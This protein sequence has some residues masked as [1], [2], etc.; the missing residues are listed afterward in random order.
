MIFRTPKVGYVN[1]PWR[2]YFW[3][4]FGLG[5]FGTV[6]FCPKARWIL[7]S[8]NGRE[9]KRCIFGVEFKT[10]IIYIYI[11]IL[12]SIYSNMEGALSMPFFSPYQRL[13]QKTSRFSL[14]SE[15]LPQNLGCTTSTKC[16]KMAPETSK[17]RL[18]RCLDPQKHILKH[19]DHLV[20]G[21]IWRILWCFRKISHEIMNLFLSLDCLN[22]GRIRLHR[23]MWI[24]DECVTTVLPIGKNGTIVYLPPHETHKN[25]WNV[26]KS[27]M[28]GSI[29]AL[30]TLGRMI[31]FPWFIIDFDM[32][33][34]CKI[35]AW[36]FQGIIPEGDHELCTNISLLGY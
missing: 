33:V 22:C 15:S 31:F 16:A 20:F 9:P 29:G 32:F 19:L 5:P 24:F 11:C 13:C 28:H 17:D 14:N 21:G 2:V 30:E 4:I 25:Q 27:I 7:S 1:N 6:L 36:N 10:C 18:R 23:W 12:Y 8:Q 26:S 3:Q 34:L 35:P